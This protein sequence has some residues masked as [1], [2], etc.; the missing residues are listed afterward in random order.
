M[1]L[2]GR[3]Q[4]GIYCKGEKT[5]AVFVRG[6]WFCVRCGHDVKVAA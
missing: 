4:V 2:K 3:R 1:N 5:K 6:A